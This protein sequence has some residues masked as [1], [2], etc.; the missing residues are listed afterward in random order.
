MI[1]LLVFDFDKTNHLILRDPALMHPES[2]PLVNPMVHFFKV[3]FFVNYFLTMYLNRTK[4]K[5]GTMKLKVYD[6]NYMGD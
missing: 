4:R 5:Y 1:I 6:K 3:Y 2:A